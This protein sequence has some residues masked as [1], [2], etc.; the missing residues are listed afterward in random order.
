MIRVIVYLVIVALLA[1]GAVWLADRPGDVA[2]TWQGQ[3]L[4]TSL[5]V[6]IMAVAAIAVL[7]VVLWSIIRGLIEAPARISRH[8]RTRRGERGYRAV[9][10]GLIAV[11]SGDVRAARRFVHEAKRIAPNEPLTLLLSAQTAQL[12]GDSLGAAATFQEMA[13]REDTR[14]LGLHGLFVEAQRRNDHAGALLYAEEASKHAAGPGT[15]PAW[16]GHAVLEFR[17]AAGDW[18]GALERLERNMKSGLVDKAA[19]RRQ[20]A[21]LL[22]AQAL[23]AEDAAAAMSSGSELG[24]ERAQALAL[25]AVK[26]APDLV[27]A[28]ALAGRLLGAAGERR[29]AA[30]IIEAAWRI[31]PHPD[32]AHAYAHLRPGD[33]ARERLARIETLADK[34]AGDVEAAIAVARAALDAQE[35]AA[36]R[37]AL[38][39]LVAQPTQRVAALMAA[40]EMKL[41]DE[42]RGREWMARALNARRDPAWT[43]DGFV[44]ERWLP[45]SPVT[46]RLDAFE[47]KDPLAGQDH[48][49][50]L[51]DAEQRAMLEAPPAPAPQAPQAIN[52][53]QAMNAA[54]AVNAPPK[55]GPPQAEDAQPA[56]VPEQPARFH[57]A[58]GDTG[59]SA[60]GA[61]GARAEAAQT[62]DD[63]VDAPAPAVIPLVHAP[64]DPG[65]DP[66]APAVEPAVEPP[67][68]PPP[69][70]WSRFRSFFK[71]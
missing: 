36:A 44:S 68:A 48:A 40:L 32:L 19:Y 66:D 30:R 12:A 54:Q 69:D 4:D 56:A 33:S 47:W 2:I 31:N 26:L 22:T 70:A 63:E 52:A 13:G 5:M 65:A 29:K 23:G 49:G 24:R 35:F 8:L 41:G 46:G 57:P 51:I 60:A 43:A 15:V 71:P 59:S 16:A 53:P 7:T 1:L 38:A 39:P 50:T 61:S 6:L 58:A 45:V 34:A 28:A 3:R 37:A 27:P 67:P 11:G 62:E 42:G 9:S 20:R 18:S 14:V 17:C 64:D 55:M 10:R 21:V 25:E